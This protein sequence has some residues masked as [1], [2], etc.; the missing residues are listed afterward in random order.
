MYLLA[1][2]GIS[3][4]VSV[5]TKAGVSE[6]FKEN[7]IFNEHSVGYLIIDYILIIL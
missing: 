1:L 7:T 4:V 5:Y 2:C 3:L 6:H